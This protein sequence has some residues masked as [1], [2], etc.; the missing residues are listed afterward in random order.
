MRYGLRWRSMGGRT[1]FTIFEMVIFTMP[2]LFACACLLGCF[3]I[4]Q[5]TFFL[6]RFKSG[7]LLCSMLLSPSRPPLTT[8]QGPS[9]PGPRC[10][11]PSPYTP[12]FPARPASDAL[13]ALL[14]GFTTL[15]WTPPPADTTEFS[16]E[17]P[18]MSTLFD[19]KPSAEQKQRLLWYAK[20]RSEVRLAA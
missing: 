14:T 20:V 18:P 19:R 16:R 9:H 11:T 17:I 15:T 2:P 7:F 10:Q 12:P 3:Q 1:T 4:P 8:T 13:A 6:A 5:S